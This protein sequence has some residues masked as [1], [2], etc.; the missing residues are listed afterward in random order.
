MVVSGSGMKSW[1]V[2]IALSILPNMQN[3]GVVDADQAPQVPCF[4]IFGD[5]LVDCGNN[6]HL[7]T[8]AKVNY[9]PYGID[10][11]NGPTGRFCN[12]RTIVDIMAELLGFRNHIPPFASVSAS[13]ILKGVNYAS[14]S[15]GILHDTGKHMGDCIS[16]G[17]QLKHHK[18]TVSH[19]SDLVGGR[20]SARKYLANCLYWLAIGNNDYI[21][22]YF[23]PKHYSSSRHYTPEQ[24]ADLLIKQYSRKIMSLYKYG[25][26]KIALIGLGLIG[27]SPNAMLSHSKDGSGPV[28]VDSMNKA[29]LIFNKQLKSLSDRLN[30]NSTEAQFIYIN[31]Y[32]TDSNNS[33]T[34]LGFEVMNVGCCPV[35][36]IGQ[37]DPSKTPC[38][39]RNSY[40][41]WDSFHPTEAAN[42]VTAQNIYTRS[43]L[44]QLLQS[45]NDNKSGLSSSSKRL[46]ARIIMVETRSTATGKK[47]IGHMAVDSI[48]GV[49][50]KKPTVSAAVGDVNE[51]KETDEP[52]VPWMSLNRDLIPDRG[53]GTK[54]LKSEK[55]LVE[56]VNQLNSPREI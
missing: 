16:L 56:S 55:R 33:S 27:C 53:T 25:A 42:L 17:R 39:K 15:A 24:Y 14:G 20:S 45:S 48:Y 28:C 52:V 46:L 18:T 37:C 32:E 34:S 54:W 10:Y 21:N 31:P 6:N 5:S 2:V 23:M 43:D 47:S 50:E 4:F 49:N 36:E 13:Q 19:I 7:H 41:F 29:V 1:W 40:V 51:H 3:Y 38:E 11:P 44:I 8:Q 30:A 22:N 12:G 26:R 9:E 35:N